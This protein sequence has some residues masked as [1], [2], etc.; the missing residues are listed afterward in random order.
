[1]RRIT[2]ATLAILLFQGVAGCVQ[3][4]AQDT[5]AFQVRDSAGV[6]IADN[7]AGEWTE[8]TAWK[9]SS[10][11]ILTIG[12]FDGPEEYLLFQASGARRL[13]NG[14]ILIAN[15]GTHELRFYDPDGTHIRS[16]GG[17]GDGPGE[18]RAMREPWPLG[19]DSIVIWDSRIARL[20]VFD[21]DG[22]F[23][24]S[25]ELNPIPDALYPTPQ[26]ILADNSL[27]VAASMGFVVPPPMGIHRDSILYTRY[28]LEGARTATVIRSQ[29]AQWNIGMLDGSQIIAWVPDAPNPAA[30]IFG[31]RWYFGSGETWEI[32]VYSPEGALTHRLRRDAPNRLFVPEIED[33]DPEMA[34]GLARFWA[35]MPILETFPAYRS[36]IVSDDGNLW[37][38]NYT[39]PS[40]QPSWAVF[41][42][43]GRY[44][45]DVDTPMGAQVTHIGDDFVLVIW[46]DELEVQQVQMYELIKP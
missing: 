8:A 13:S 44:L 45:G 46:E 7:F 24:R 3:D 16:V 12:E 23:G 10:D 2:T 37:V 42:N 21:T 39:R 6:T 17:E 1:M 25:F 28:S 11:P 14:N 34:P 35:S 31:D 4:P 15:G 22:E 18:F 20:T 27:L 40:E 38:E 32:E 19:S 41:R 30:T 29:G 43:D 5:Q 9:L 36:I 33:E 26:G